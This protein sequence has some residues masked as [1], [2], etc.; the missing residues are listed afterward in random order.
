VTTIL[1][2]SWRADGDWR[3]LSLAVHSLSIYAPSVPVLVGWRGPVAPSLGYHVAKCLRRP[4]EV[5]S[6]SQA[7]QWLAEQT[8]DDDLIIWSDDCVATPD[9]LRV[10]LRDV[11]LLRPE[12]P[13]MVAPR[14]NFAAG[15]QNVRH[16]NGSHRL[17]LQ[18]E[19]EAQIVE[20]TFLAP[21]VAWFPREALPHMVPVDHE[22]YSDNMACDNLR[23][24]GFRLFVSTAYVHHVGM[25]SSKAAGLSMEDMDRMGR[26]GVGL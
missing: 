15:A 2:P 7:V 12:Q 13:G 23:A 26:E 17:G 5:Q 18:W 24:A 6:S 19:S 1:L 20:T 10:L 4:D 11:E 16:P 8:D 21:F 25:R 9:T 14:S 3:D 22:W